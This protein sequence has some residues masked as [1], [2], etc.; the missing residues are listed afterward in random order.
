MTQTSTFAHSAC[1]PRRCWGV[2]FALGGVACLLVCMQTSV[3]AQPASTSGATPNVL[4]IVVDDL[5]FAD[6]ECLGSTDM[7]TPALNE[8]YAR[9][10]KLGRLYANCPVCSPT[11]ASILTGRYPDRV[12]VPGVIRTH[13]EN[14]WGYFAPPAPTLPQRLRQRGYHTAAVGKWHLGL[15]SENHPNQRGFDFFHGFLG[16]MMDDYF[17]HRRHDINYM[18][19]DA[20]EID[21]SGHATE[22]FSVW[23]TD[24]ITSRADES[25]PWFLYLA[26]NAP[27]TPIQPPSDWIDKVA[28]RQPELS[29]ERTKLVALIEHMDDGI[30]RVLDALRST[31]QFENTIIVFTSDNGGQVSVG[32]NNGDLRDG[33]GSMYEGGL[34]IPGCIRVPGQTQD[35]SVTDAVCVTMDILPTLIEIIG[36]ETSD[37]SELIDGRSW[38]PLFA[39]PDQRDDGR[40]VFFVR[41]EGGVQYGGLTIEAVLK[42][43]LKLV[44]NFP[45]HSFELFDLL[46]DPAEATDLAKKQPKVFRE[47][48]ERLQK[49]VQRGGQLPWQKGESSS[50]PASPSETN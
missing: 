49:H 8:L 12:G 5:G 41:R 44:H 4:V 34:R 2:V 38:T 31:K 39:D 6:L 3:N 18:R 33:K 15:R 16:D 20:E 11:R 47:M 27:H 26:Y 21:P 30:G 13:D 10:L 40:E 22:L 36:G 35:G 29:P 28:Y 32:A 23:A 46:A 7:R 19:R 45:T 25:S 17:N 9:S 43:N 37:A 50:H 1:M 14:S 24:Y 42:G 48:L